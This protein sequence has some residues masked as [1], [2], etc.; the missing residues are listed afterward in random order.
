MAKVANILRTF[1]S[2]V[3]STDDAAHGLPSTKLCRVRAPAGKPSRSAAPANCLNHLYYNFI[4]SRSASV[5][6]PGT[7]ASIPY[8][9]TQTRTFA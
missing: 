7:V 8:D 1:F 9:D 4:E 2:T 3:D 6:T 5:R